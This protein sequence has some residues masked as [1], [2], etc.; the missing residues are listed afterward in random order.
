MTAALRLQE[1]FVLGDRKI[2]PVVS[3][4]SL[5]LEHGTTAL[6]NPVAL[7]IEDHGHITCAVLGDASPEEIVGHLI[8][9]FD[10]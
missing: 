9:G 8:A 10:R 5:S 1:P 4:V 3:L 7:I 2:Y 6:L